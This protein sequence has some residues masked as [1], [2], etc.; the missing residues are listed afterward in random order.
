MA[1]NVTIPATGSGTATPVIAA[2]DVSSVFYQ[3][4]KLDLGGDGAASPLVRGQQTAAN[5]I[6]I[7]TPSDEFVTVLGSVTRPNDT[8]T[9]AAG[10]AFADSA[11]APTSGGFTLTGAARASGGSG[12]IT[13]MVISLSTNQATSLMGEIWLFDQGVGTAPNDNAA[14]AISDGAAQICVGIVPFLLNKSGTNNALYHAQNL[15]IGFTCVGS[16]NL[17]FLV[18]VLNAYIPTASEFLSVSTHIIRF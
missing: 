5:G 3:R 13:D 8:N 17:R 12:I 7:V 2:D 11:S 6:P 16:A 14:F 9:Y 18:K 1:D 10:D 4:V 15:N